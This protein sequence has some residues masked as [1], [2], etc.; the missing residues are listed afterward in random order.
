M[1][2]SHAIYVLV[3]AE[4]K[5]VDAFLSYSEAVRESHRGARIIRVA[6]RE[7]Y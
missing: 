5:F 2:K 6:Y 3:D 7:D 1:S 4:G